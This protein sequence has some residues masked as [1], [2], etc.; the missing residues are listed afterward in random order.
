MKFNLR[1]RAGDWPE[2]MEFRPDFR[3][4]AREIAAAIHCESLHVLASSKNSSARAAAAGD[5]SS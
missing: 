5:A 3:R 2:F 1:E 4:V